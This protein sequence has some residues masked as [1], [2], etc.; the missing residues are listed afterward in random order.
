VDRLPRRRAQQSEYR[1]EL[2]KA[3]FEDIDVEPTRIYTAE[4]ARDLLRRQARRR[5]DRRCHGEF[6]SAFVRA[7]KPVR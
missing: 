2:A 7:R 6:V 5:R 1:G 4:S 3:G